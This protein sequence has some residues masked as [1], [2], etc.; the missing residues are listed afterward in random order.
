MYHKGGTFH[1]FFV[2]SMDKKRERDIFVHI[3]R[4]CYQES[5]K[6][7]VHTIRV[8]ISSLF[9]SFYGIKKQKAYFVQQTRVKLHTKGGGNVHISEVCAKKN[10]VPINRVR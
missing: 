2:L 8:G 1:H 7:E 6:C 10:E 5:K 9:L 4:L 3:P